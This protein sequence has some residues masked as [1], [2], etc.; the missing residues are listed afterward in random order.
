MGATKSYVRKS[1]KAVTWTLLA[2]ARRKLR[3][4]G[5]NLR[6]CCAYQA[7][8][9]KGSVFL[10][11]S[12]YTLLDACVS[13][14]SE[15]LAAN[16]MKDMITSCKLKDNG[17]ARDNVMIASFALYLIDNWNEEQGKRKIVL[18]IEAKWLAVSL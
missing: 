15:Y 11:R 5:L 7:T 6:R 18:L 9:K 17:L 12:M 8:G 14:G 10:W 2:W 16:G 3:N 4:L 13:K 1:G